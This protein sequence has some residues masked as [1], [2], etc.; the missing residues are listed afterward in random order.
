MPHQP[1][2]NPTDPRYYDEKDLRSEVERIFGLCADCRM[3][4]KFCGS[5][6]KMFDAVDDYCTEGKYAEVDTKKFKSEDLKH[7][8]DL[9]FQC[10]LCYIKCPYT[11][12][13]HDWAIDFPR[14][15]ARAK[16]QE[17]KKNGVPLADKLL[18]S[19]D[20]LGKLGTA[21]APLANWGNEN[22]LNRQLM[23]SVVGIHKDKKLPPFASKTFAAQFESQRKAPQGE[24]A[25]K[26]AFFSTCYVNYNQPEIGTDTLEVMARNNVDVVF[27][28]ERCCG[29]PLWHNGDMD[30]AVEAA[31]QNVTDLVRYVQ[32]NRS[33]VATNPTCSQMI[34]VEYPRLLGTDDAKKVAARTIDPMEFLAGLASTGKLN[35]AFKTGAGK[36]SYHMPCHLRAQNVGYKTRDVLSLLP[37]T[38]VRVV[39]ECSGHDGTW[40]MKKENFEQSLKWGSRAFKEMAE[41]NPKVT[42]S[43]C[44][45]AAIQIE[46][47]NG[48]R[49]LNPMQILAKSYRGE[50]IG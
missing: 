33:I 32:D 6:P 37:E 38:T 36:I 29:M 50:A 49:P 25:A 46:Q 19:P 44:P 16:A 20:L 1:A 22:A 42:C 14:L 23:H 21:T 12:G 5:F 7:V 9:C 41:G 13:D 2:Y 24:P 28:Y 17:V 34:R 27:G 10:K 35:K 8:V 15:I 45:L 4:V 3:C 31:K 26:I 18:G 39:E 11:P 48:R 43:D 30:G 40:A 47:G